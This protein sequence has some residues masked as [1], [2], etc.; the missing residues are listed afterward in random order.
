MNHWYS[1]MD[2]APAS[3]AI[4]LLGSCAP[5]TGEMYIRNR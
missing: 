1:M 3:M 5:L 4:S 2:T